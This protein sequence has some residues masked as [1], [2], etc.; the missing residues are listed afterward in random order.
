MMK[1]TQGQGPSPVHHRGTQN[2]KS[3][4]P[5]IF[6][7]GRGLKPNSKKMTQQR[8]FLIRSVSSAYISGKVCSWRVLSALIGVDP[9][10]ETWY[11]PCLCVSVVGLEASR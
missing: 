11:S 10:Q 2:S 5:R 7:D 6:A 3:F 4:L 9:R 8:W 1:G